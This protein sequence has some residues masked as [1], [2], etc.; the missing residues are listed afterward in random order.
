MLRKITCTAV[1]LI[2]AVSF[3]LARENPDSRASEGKKTPKIEQWR[4]LHLLGYD[5]DAALETLAGQ[6]PKLAEL[7]L[8]VLILEV[9]YHYR[10]QSYPKL[11][12]GRQQITPQGAAKLAA[13]C[14]KNGIRLIPQFQCLGHQSWKEET[15]PLLIVYPELDL[16]PGAFPGNEKI[17]CREW[18]PLNPKVNEIVFKLIDATIGLRVKPAVEAEGLDMDEMGVPGYVGVVDNL[19]MPELGGHAP[20]GV[21]KPV[22][23]ESR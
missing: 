20:I 23:A 11:R 16:T 21:R 22:P 1:L 19:A 18:D 8:N 4:G 5:S 15:F 14:R 13:V 9:D 2:V 17:Y 10:F 6:I 7:G 12:Q 3:L